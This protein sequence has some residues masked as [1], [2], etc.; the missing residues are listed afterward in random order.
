MAEFQNQLNRLADGLENGSLSA[1][2]CAALLRRLA[3]VPAVCALS[4]APASE[5]TSGGPGPGQ[6]PCMRC[7]HCGIAADFRSFQCGENRPEFFSEPGGLACSSFSS[8]Y[9][10]YPIQVEGIRVEE[11]FSLNERAPGQLA[12]V[13]PCG[14]NP[15]GRT[16]LGF[17]L[18]E[19]PTQP[20]ASYQIK[21]RV[22]K[23]G[24]A[25]NPAIYVPELGRI[26]WGAESFWSR[27][28]SKDALREISDKD[29]S[30]QWYVQALR[31]VSG[32][33]GE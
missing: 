6:S 22:L 27:V 7:R 14:D 30:S 13:R 19:L 31:R 23:V 20:Y 4:P 28:S 33:E 3:A 15:E 2:E 21:E 26:V 25:A 17:F 1:G 18:G 29:I 16:Y 24:M 5:D 11:V 10:E 12:R 8:R 32:Q 9:I